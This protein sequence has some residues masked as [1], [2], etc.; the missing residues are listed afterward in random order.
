MN[1][2]IFIKLLKEHTDIDI[3]FINTFF[4]NFKIGEELDFNIK[5]INVANY[6]GIQLRTLRERLQNK[7]SKNNIFIQNVDFIKVKTKGTSSV[8]YLL[9][10][11]CFEKIAMNGDSPKSESVRM[12][13]IKLREFL[14][15]NQH[16]IY[17][18]MNTK[19]ELK[20][21]SNMETIYFFV[22]DV[23]NPDI[24]KIGRTTDII[25]RLRN[26]NTGR[27]NEVQLKYFA[28]VKN[29]LIIEKCMKLKLRKNQVYENKEIYKVDPEKVKKIIK[30]CYCKYVSKTENEELYNEVSSLLGLYS[31][32][33]N[34]I[35]IKPFVIINK[36]D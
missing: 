26:Y 28:L 18:S 16:I 5:D 11:P 31:Y 4:K 10:Y 19:Q 33:R 29:N 21:Y 32:A 22:I 8:M 36:N 7:Y 15:K 23:R 12:Y 20:K 2:E 9:N 24:L 35:N 25:K 17:Q 1:S 27:V 13:F 6:L 34:K 3:K 30:D 14:L